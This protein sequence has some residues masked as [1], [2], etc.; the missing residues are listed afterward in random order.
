VIKKC[1]GALTTNF[2]KQGLYC[3]F[4]I[5]CD[6]VYNDVLLPLWQLLRSL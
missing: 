2:H 6:R 5:Q 3:R 4:C 1:Q